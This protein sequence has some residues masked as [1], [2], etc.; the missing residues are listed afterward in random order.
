MGGVELNYRVELADFREASYYMLFIRKRTAFRLAI[1]ILLAF[2]VYVVLCLNHVTNMEPVAAFIAGAYLI[3]ILLQ[4]ASVEREILRYAKTPDTLISEEYSAKFGNRQFS[5]AIPA[6]GFS[7]TDD[8]I[9]LHC[10]FEIAH[11]FLLYVSGQQMF[12]IPTRDMTEEEALT[13]RSILTS[14]LGE[15]FHSLFANNSQRRKQ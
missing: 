12:I 8:I 4:L 14:A 2:F 11:C 13:L 3:W 9:N 15:R 1:L 5:I 7:V 10:A 6:R